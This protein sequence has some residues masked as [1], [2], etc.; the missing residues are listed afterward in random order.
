MIISLRRLLRT[1]APWLIGILAICLFIYWPGLHGSFLFDDFPNIV[2]N[3]NVHV[4]SLTLREWSQAAL[5]SPASEL[6]RPLSMLSFAANEYF[7][8]SHPFPMKLTNLV[9]HLLNG[10]LLFLFLIAL[11]KLWNRTLA[12]PFSKNQLAWIAFSV[13]S[14][15]LLAPI[16]LTSVLYV[17]QR[18]ESLAQTFVLLGLWGYVVSRARLLDGKPGMTQL[19]TVLCSCTVL[20]LLC[21]ETAVLLPFYA[22]LIELAILGFEGKDPAVKKRLHLFYILFL[23]LPG[24]AGLAWLAPRT[25]GPGTYIGRPF[26]IG[27]RL[28]T[29]LR[30]VTD[31]IGWTLL[32]LPDQLSFYHDDIALS[33]SL[34]NPPQTLVCIIF[35]MGLLSVA[36]WQRR[37][38]ALL[39]LGLLWFFAAHSLTATIIPLELVF[40]HRNYFASIGLFIAAADIV[41]LLPLQLKLVRWLAPI[42]MGTLLAFTTALRAQEWSNPLR[43]AYTE[44]AEHPLSPRANY[45]LGRLL[46]I[47]SN[48][49]SDSPFVPEAIKVLDRARLLPGSSALPE[50]ALLLLAYH[51][52]QPVDIQW[53]QSLETKLRVQPLSAEDI[54]S[55]QSL[56][57]CEVQ[58]KCPIRPDQML[59][60][61]LAALSH[62]NPPS[63]LLG[64]YSDFAVAVLHDY[65]LAER[66]LVQAAA[67]TSDN[68]R[69]RHDLL[70][71]RR[72]EGNKDATNVLSNETQKSSSVQVQPQTAVSS[73]P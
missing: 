30:V 20:G 29:E 69:Y 48:Y 7:T 68:E 45:E 36:L 19:A 66:L 28:L 56:L 57:S 15:W 61:F 47:A 6:K 49:K 55:L 58:D 38:H 3:P 34:I 17:V 73:T 5:A 65:A 16:N 13:T 42:G 26:T 8:G 35:L 2:D 43:L 33:S 60:L 32:P 50:S 62:P 70:R 14:A 71:V 67:T 9:I 22:A 12:V 4:T 53:Y 54:S 59:S 46:V 24:L 18:M 44:V 63:R 1:P 72:L 11:F 31:Y 23:V 25:F 52:H 27:Q 39:S 21:K 41:L 40:E 37:R 51:T 64:I 10:V